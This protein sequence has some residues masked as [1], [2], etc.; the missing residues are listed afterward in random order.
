MVIA[1][2]GSMVVPSPRFWRT[3]ATAWGGEI[4]SCKYG[5][6]SKLVLSPRKLLIAAAGCL[7]LLIGAA[8]SSQQSKAAGITYNVD[9]TVGAGSVTGDIVTDGTIGDINSA[10]ILD[11]NLLLNSDSTTF[12][13]L[14]PLS[15]SNSFV[16]S[17]GVNLS[18]TATQLLFNFSGGSDYLAFQSGSGAYGGTVL[19]FAADLSCVLAGS[20]SGESL[21]INNDSSTVQFTDLSGTQVVGTVAGFPSPSIPEPSTLALLGTGLLGLMS[22]RR[23]EHP[24]GIGI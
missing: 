19:C 6:V 1:I 21:V 11:W 23:R 8:A 20:G 13:L 9:L 16:G 2:P 5:I 12:D 22:S 15:G 24:W 10:Y 4:M 3:V 7:L 17:S 18:A 14:G